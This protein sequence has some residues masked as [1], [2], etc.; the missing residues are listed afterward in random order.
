MATARL[1]ALGS[2]LAATILVVYQPVPR[3]AG[4]AALIGWAGAALL[5]AGLAMGYRGAVSVAAVAFVIRIAVLA[6]LEVELRPPIWAQALLIALLV[7]LAGMSF[8]LRSRPGDPL[9]LVVRGVTAALGAAVL[10]EVLAVL[11]GVTTAS[12]TLVRVAGMTAV[13]VA[14]GWVTRVWRRSGLSG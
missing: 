8:T 12:G 9:R 3:I 10:V 14:A 13:V 7:E 11:L 5:A 2:V 6:P 4:I 1:S